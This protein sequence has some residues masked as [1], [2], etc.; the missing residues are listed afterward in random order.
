MKTLPQNQIQEV[1]PISEA[2]IL[3]IKDIINTE[4]D[5]F[6]TE[7]ELAE[8]IEEGYIFGTYGNSE[9]Y[10]RDFIMGLIK[11]VDLEKNP[12]ALVEEEPVTPQEETPILEDNQA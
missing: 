4:W 11:E 9:H 12:P 5:T 2:K 10:Q 3:E 7:L 8:H 6:Y 1:T